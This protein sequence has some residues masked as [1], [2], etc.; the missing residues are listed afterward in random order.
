M[1]PRRFY[2]YRRVDETGVS[3]TGVVA[4]GVEWPDGE[5]TMRWCVKDKP[6]STAQYEEIEH[7]VKI[8]GHDGKT[9]VVWID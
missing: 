4:N 7:V 3:G 9:A 5:V 2:L 1:V 6:N 8:H